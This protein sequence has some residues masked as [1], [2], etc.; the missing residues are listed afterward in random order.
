MR[1]KGERKFAYRTKILIYLLVIAIVPMITLGCYSYYTYMEQITD[2]V[3]TTTHVTAGQTKNK[4]DTLL[5]DIRKSY[6]EAMERSEIAWVLE[7]DLDY[8]QYT[9]I[10]AATNILQGNRY[11]MDYVSGYTIINFETQ[12]VLSNR[13][14]FKYELVTN[15]EEVAALRELNKDF[16]SRFSWL[17][18]TSNS[19][20]QRLNRET[21]NLNG[22][23]LVLQVPSIAREPHGLVVININQDKLIRLI[24]ETREADIT[25]LNKSGDIVYTDNPEVAA[26]CTEHIEELVDMR[27][28]N[29]EFKGENKHIISVEDSDAL[30]WIYV[31][32][33]DLS[34]A[35]AGASGIISLMTILIVTVGLLLISIKLFTHR[36]YNPLSNLMNYVNKALITDEQGTKTNE[37]EYLT[38]SFGELVSKKENL[39]GVLGKQQTQLTEL[40]QLRLIEGDIK[41]EQLGA[42]G[43]RLNLPKFEYYAILSIDLVMTHSL[44]GNE[45]VA[46]NTLHDVVRMEVIE[47]MPQSIRDKLFMHPVCNYRAISMIVGANDLDT[48]EHYT[49]AL[50]TEMEEY[51]KSQYT[52]SIHCGVSASFDA[53]ID[54]RK[55]YN[56]SL[57]ALK[58]QGLLVLNTNH[59]HSE[60]IFYTDIQA[61]EVYGYDV[62]LEKQLKE[63]I[64]GSELVE[65]FGIVE[66]FIEE[67]VIHKVSQTDRQIYLHRL[68]INLLS[69][70]S[71]TGLSIETLLS[72]EDRNIFMNLNQIYDMNKLKNFYKYKII[73]PVIEALNAH[74]AS[75]AGTI[76]E[77]IKELVRE[78][79]GD[80]SLTECAE[81]LH[82]HPT[83]IWKV[84]KLEGEATFSDFVA[85]Y[86]LSEAKRLLDETS[87]TVAEIAQQLNYTNTQNFIRF[88]SKLEGTTPGKYR[89]RDQ[90]SYKKDAI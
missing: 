56:Q 10:V 4:V 58:N 1:K 32:S 76:M 68:L 3:R 77:A 17:D 20:S 61:S 37:F 8:S 43:Q 2:K 72:E 65:A 82:Y 57:D 28:K 86:K 38:N 22:L 33:S 81:R 79:K 7:N 84:M 55:A 60:I 74:R 42:Y 31:A 90:D 47:H 34:M 52:L 46:Q 69:V 9:Y 71:D 62:V 75:K 16:F 87:L 89:K 26:Y 67:L 88:F 13:G 59:T 78:T 53:L 85:E 18:N 35:H 12:W 73:A 41:E 49:M 11:L 5:V 63:A 80:I 70:M 83:Y 66:V 50:Y 44:V 40:F 30:N 54:Y 27:G 24:E 21:I 45:A 14:M 39:E 51:I 36:I 19:S 25:I 64:G 15:K 23:S 6:M 48:L 29:G